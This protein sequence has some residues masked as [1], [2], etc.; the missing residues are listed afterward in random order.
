MSK[1][2]FRLTES[3]EIDIMLNESKYRR[4]L[5]NAA[6]DMLMERQ[7]PI[8]RIIMILLGAGMTAAACL[9][10]KQYG[11]GQSEILRHADVY[12][13]PATGPHMAP[14]PPTDFSGN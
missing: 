8:W 2:K 14:T 12:P 1:N 9:V 3:E 7:H 11:I 10:G 5:T 6:T 13:Y 4:G